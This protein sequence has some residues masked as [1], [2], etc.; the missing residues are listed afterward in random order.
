MTRIKKLIKD[1][2][3]P[4]SENSLVDTL[5]ITE[6][7]IKKWNTI[8]NTEKQLVKDNFPVLYGIKPI[9]SRSISTNKHG[10]GEVEVNLH[11]GSSAK[12]IDTLYVPRSEFSRV[13]K[14]LRE[15]GHTHIEVHDIQ[16]IIDAYN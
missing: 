15:G 3:F 5:K 2:V 10:F 1:K 12:E 11:G 9:K 7:Q 16:P 13:K 4:G 14:L 6:A 8:S